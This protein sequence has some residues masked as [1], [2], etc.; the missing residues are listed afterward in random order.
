MEADHSEGK[1]LA[2]FSNLNCFLTPENWDDLK[3]DHVK[4][5][6]VLY[7]L[8]DPV[9][10]VWSHFKYHLQFSKHPAAKAPD[11]DFT[12]FKSILQKDWFL[13]NA[14]YAQTAS[15][16]GSGLSEEQLKIA[17]FED[18]IAEPDAFLVELGRFLALRPFEYTGDLYKRKN[19]SIR[20]DIPAEWQNYIRTVLK[21]EFQSMREGGIWHD[22]WENS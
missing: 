5:L 16:L 9:K 19:T 8:R 12:L 1:H 6:R 21:T 17:Y 22:Q 20:A 4:N 15:A 11:K 7:I 14:F 18:M 2:D 3:R 10:R 13:R